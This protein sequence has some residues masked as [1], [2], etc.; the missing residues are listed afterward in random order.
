MAQV[1]LPVPFF[2]NL[3]LEPS[4]LRHSARVLTTSH[5]PTHNTLHHTLHHITSHYITLHHITSHYITL[6]H[7]TS[8]YITLHHITSH[9]I[10]LHHITSH[11]ITLHVPYIIY[12][13]FI[14]SLY[15]IRIIHLHL[16]ARCSD[17]VMQWHGHG[18]HWR[19]LRVS[20]ILS[21]SQPISARRSEIFSKSQLR[22]WSETFLT[23]RKP[24]KLFTEPVWNHII[25]ANVFFFAK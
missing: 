8:H 16:S 13:F 3:A 22:K 23:I 19:N 24:K 14:I 20:E 15:I 2:F 25:F 10:T 1:D 17:G 9:H 21:P 7:I 5:V 6:H 12:R 11:Y 4:H 18:G